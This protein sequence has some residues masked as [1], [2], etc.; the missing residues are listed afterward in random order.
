LRG[1]VF[2][3]VLAVALD[4]AAALEV[5]GPQELV[6]LP[7]GG[8]AQHTV[9]LNNPTDRPEKITVSYY[10]EQCPDAGAQRDYLQMLDS[11]QQK[12]AVQLEPNSFQEYSWTIQTAEHTA[13]GRYL[14]WVVFTR[15]TY[16]Q[17][18]AESVFVVQEA[19]SFPLR[20]ECLA[21]VIN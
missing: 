8:S 11:L 17:S 21:P 2:L 6:R 7:R 5:K 14:F 18:S 12:A 1:L 15:D 4:S 16:T 19:S 13:L 3:L 20:V 9:L 10:L